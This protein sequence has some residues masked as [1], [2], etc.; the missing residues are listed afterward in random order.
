MSSSQTQD[1]RIGEAVMT[2]RESTPSITFTAADS[3]HSASRPPSVSPFAD[4]IVPVTPLSARSPA[5]TSIASLARAGDLRNRYFRS[6]RIKDATEVQKPWLEKSDP[7]EKWVT[8]IPLIAIFI[9]LGIAAYLVY[10]GVASVINHKYCEVLM[11]DFSQGFRS[12]IWS[13][14]VEL[15]GF[16]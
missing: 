8:I 15:G 14:D 11:E 1:F 3:R 4:P 2:T 7:R 12:E 9:G 16:G 10:D 13:H 6:R 5:A